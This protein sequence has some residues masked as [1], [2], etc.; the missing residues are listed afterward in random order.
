MH[1]KTPCSTL[2]VIRDC[3]VAE[4]EAVLALWRKAE[5]TVSP[6]DTVADLHRALTAS[7]A[8]VLV[9]D[10]EGQIIGSVIGSFDGWRGNIYRLVVHPDY[11]RHGIA[12]ALVKEVEQRL[13]CQDAGR[14]TA[15]VEK[16]HPWAMGFW[17]AV[18][19]EIDSRMVRFI[20]EL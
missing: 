18:G 5:T 20:N 10:T 1:I 17:H 3:R 16:E 11:H 4:V 12:R 8:I 19:Y 6:T 15:W 13:A 9:A 2:W 14:I 7:P